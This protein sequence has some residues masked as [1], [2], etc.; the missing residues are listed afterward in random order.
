MSV[1]IRMYM[2]KLIRQLMKSTQAYIHY[3]NIQA[4]NMPCGTCVLCMGLA[5]MATKFLDARACTVANVWA[6]DD[7]HVHE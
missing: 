7:A 4:D 6:N 5:E 3:M 1:G 2:H